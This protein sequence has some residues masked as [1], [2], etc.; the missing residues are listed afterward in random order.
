MV[1][2][3]SIWI[4]IVNPTLWVG[5]LFLSLTQWAAVRTCLSAMMDPP[6]VLE[7]CSVLNMDTMNGSGSKVHNKK[8]TSFLPANTICLARTVSAIYKI[9]T[10]KSLTALK[11][12]IV[13][14]YS[15]STKFSGATFTK[16]SKLWFIT[17][18]ILIQQTYHGKGNWHYFNYVKN[19][20]L[21]EGK[22]HSRHSISE[23]K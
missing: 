3:I 4:K 22:H 21:T 17:C 18:S 20:A 23:L 7:L 12:L 15:L 5:H 16:G 10:Q 8:Y 14:V 9:N 6:Q 11:K 13:V 1:S 19:L 2:I